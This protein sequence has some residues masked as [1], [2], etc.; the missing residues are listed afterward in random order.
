MKMLKVMLIVLCLGCAVFAIGCGD[1]ELPT[2]KITRD[3][4]RVG[5]SLSFVFDKNEGVVYVGGEDEYLTYTTGDESKGYAEG[6]RVGLKVTAPDV[7]LD[8]DNAV[9]EMNDVTYSAGDFLESINGVNQRFFYI[10]PS[11]DKKNNEA[12]FSITWQEGTK[13]QE[14]RVIVVDGTKFLNKDGE[15]I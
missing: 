1:K 5:G 10:Y 4:A 7:E 15:I 2:A 3:E 13:Q 9:L 6:N 11:F 8:L 12:T 14:Y